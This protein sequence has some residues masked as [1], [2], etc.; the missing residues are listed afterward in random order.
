EAH[1]GHMSTT[2]VGGKPSDVVLGVMATGRDAA[3]QVA[4]YGTALA[5]MA[6]RL[7]W[8]GSAPVRAMVPHR[9]R[10]AAR[11]IAEAIETELRSRVVELAQRGE[12]ERRR[13]HRYASELLD[14]LVPLIVDAVAVR[15]D[16]AAVADRLDLAAITDEILDEID[17]PEI[18]RTSS[19]SLASNVVVGV[20]RRGME[21]DDVVASVADRLLRRESPMTTRREVG[22][23]LHLS[24]VPKGARPLQGRTAGF[25]TRAMAGV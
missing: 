10:A 7:A 14:R 17:L 2:A 20:R 4:E 16:V 24:G 6:A 12:M 15:I 21:V 11:N 18:I 13:Q 19:G 25:A 5:G 1:T 8:H 9:Y 3:V 23:S 22:P